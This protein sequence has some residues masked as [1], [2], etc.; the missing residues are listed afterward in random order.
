M[1]PF[2]N[3]KLLPKYQVFK[4]QVEARAKQSRKENNQE[5]QQA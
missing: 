1:L 2:E 5:P 4:E 3:A